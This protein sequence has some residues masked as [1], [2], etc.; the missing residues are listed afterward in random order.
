[1]SMHHDPGAGTQNQGN[2]LGTRPIIRQSKYFRQ[3]ESGNATKSL[4]GM[5]NLTW[6]TEKTEGCFAGR[7]VHSEY[8]QRG[9]AQQKFS[10]ELKK[11][12]QT[13]HEIKQ[14]RQRQH[15]IQQQQYALQQQPEQQ[16][17]IL[18]Q[19]LEQQQYNQQQQR[20]NDALDVLISSSPKPSP[21]RVG[22]NPLSQ[23]NYTNTK[24]QDSRWETTSSS[25]GRF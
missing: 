7:R 15:Y 21:T 18:I 23:Q 9:Y 11:K 10:A 5:S 6:D 20:Q 3:Y 22:S 4:L 24:P 1:M 16:T 25:Y 8:S 17:T 14:L 13:D 12:Q 19:Q 2:S